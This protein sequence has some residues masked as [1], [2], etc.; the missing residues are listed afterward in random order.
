[1]T[2]TL[3]A[4]RLLRW[5][6][7]MSLGMYTT[8]KCYGSGEYPPTFVLHIW[9]VS[10]FGIHFS[11]SPS[12]SPNL[13][14]IAYLRYQVIELLRTI[15]IKQANLE[16]PKSPSLTISEWISPDLLSLSARKLFWS[17]TMHLTGSS[18]PDACL[19]YGRSST[20]PLPNPKS[21]RQDMRSRLKI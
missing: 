21:M 7:C 11:D 12:P 20:S 14:G 1:M 8:V 19:L 15:D 17:V 16:D 13:S 3:R 2:R 4:V 6:Y 10:L 9:P 5:L 18:S